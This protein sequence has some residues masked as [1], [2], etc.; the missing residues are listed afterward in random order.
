MAD[1]DIPC[2]AADAMRRVKQVD[3]DGIVVGITMLEESVREVREMNLW[4]KKEIS[5]L[6]LKKVKVYNYIPAAAEVKYREALV[7][8]YENRSD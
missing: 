8:E 3:V 7:R 4:N 2:C 1:R 6:L 5:D